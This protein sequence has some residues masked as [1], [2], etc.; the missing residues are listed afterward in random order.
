MVVSFC[1][2]DPIS[3]RQRGWGSSKI[4]LKPHARTRKEACVGPEAP[5]PQALHCRD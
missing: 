5:K 4:D 1:G 3:K 2:N